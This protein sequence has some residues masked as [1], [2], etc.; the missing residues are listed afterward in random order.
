MAATES[1]TIGRLLSWTTDYLRDRRADSPRLDAEVLLAHARGCQRI[2]L[3]TSYD[4]EPGD[5]VR[6]KFRELVRRRAEGTPV[7]YLV[8]QREFYS[9]PF[10]VT[11]DTL[12]PR[13]ETEHLVIELL[14]RARP[15]ELAG[16]SL[17]IADVGTGSGV[18]A[19]CLAK[20]LP[21]AR[22]MATDTS[23]QALDVARGNAAAHD[24][25]ERI[26]FVHCDVLGGVPADRRLDAVVSNPPYVRSNEMAALPRDVRDFEPS[27]ALDGG[28]E[29]VD[30]IARLAPQAAERLR[31][32]GWLMVEIG[33]TVLDAARAV[34]SAE[35]RLTITDIKKDLA[36]HPRVIIARRNE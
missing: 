11:P 21:H 12:I 26:D 14:D 8:G 10:T 3:Y 13:P 7:A 36:Q 5:D 31:P 25:G 27:S 24:V 18:V 23:A 6:A 4:I 34:V 17:A 9:L 16:E 1:W 2:E 15:R 29:G 19:V 30:V 32:G 33:P 20:E 35:C 22:I 28:P